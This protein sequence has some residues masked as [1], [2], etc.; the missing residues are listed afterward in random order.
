[1]WSNKTTVINLS[2]GEWHAASF[3]FAPRAMAPL[4]VRV[5]TAR[6]AAQLA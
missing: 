6:T 1:M 5:D 3:E 2:E 4:Q